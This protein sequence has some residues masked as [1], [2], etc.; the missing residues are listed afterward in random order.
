[1]RYLDLFG[2]LM[3]LSRIAVLKA[4]GDVDNGRWVFFDG[5]R[6]RIIQKWVDSVDGMY[7]GL[8][9]FV[10]NPSGLDVKSRKLPLILPDRVLSLKRM[11]SG[12]VNFGLRVPGIMGCMREITNYTIEDEIIDLERKLGPKSI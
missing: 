6:K 4:H 8:I 2:D 3:G 1:M 11:C 7:K 10:C 9:L 5:E 12:D